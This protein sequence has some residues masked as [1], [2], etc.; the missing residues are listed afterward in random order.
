[1][2]IAEFITMEQSVVL[3]GDLAGERLEGRFW[4][5]EVV[6]AVPDAAFHFTERSAWPLGPRG[7]RPGTEGGAQVTA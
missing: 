3:L 5:S 7:E 1:M 6:Y 4:C 2:T